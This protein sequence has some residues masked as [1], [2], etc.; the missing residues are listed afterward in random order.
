MTSLWGLA[1]SSFVLRFSARRNLEV[2]VGIVDP[3]LASQLAK[4]QETQANEASEF[5]LETWRELSPIKRIICFF[6]YHILK[7]TGKP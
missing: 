4:L 6:A 5:T 7:F 3:R 2:C 1:F